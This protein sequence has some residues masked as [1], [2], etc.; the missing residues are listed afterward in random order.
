MVL[1]LS[2]ILSVPLVD[3]FAVVR[4]QDKHHGV[5][6]GLIPQHHAAYVRELRT[7]V[8]LRSEHAGVQEQEID[9]R[10]QRFAQILQRCNAGLTV[11]YWNT[12]CTLPSRLGHRFAR[13]FFNPSR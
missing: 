6:S 1:R 5:R 13:A 2:R 7:L 4:P 10:A 11:N 9:M 8:G 3:R 12:W